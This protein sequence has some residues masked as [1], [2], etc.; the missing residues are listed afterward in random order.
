MLFMLFFS[1]RKSNNGFV[2]YVYVDILINVNNPQFFD[3]GTVGG[4]MYYDGGSKGLIIH[5]VQNM[6]FMVYDRHATFR[7]NDECQVVVLP[8]NLTIE[9]PCS[10][11]QYYINDGNIMQ[12]PASLPL[13][14]Y[15]T[16]FDGTTLRIFN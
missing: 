16:T 15:N 8:D 7:S 1:C 2:P 5:R 14:T 6:G 12:G 11:S 4:W 13:K 3:I 10:G 9:D